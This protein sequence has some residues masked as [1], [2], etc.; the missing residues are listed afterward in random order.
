MQVGSVMKTGY[1]GH[2][3]V[4]LA[5]CAI[6]VRRGAKRPQPVNKKKTTAVDGDEVQLNI[7][8]IREGM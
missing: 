7:A 4:H 5:V 3:K 2:C 6:K 1:T 8:R